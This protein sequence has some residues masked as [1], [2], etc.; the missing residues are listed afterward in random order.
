M[1]ATDLAELLQKREHVWDAYNHLKGEEET[2]LVGLAPSLRGGTGRRRGTL[3][4][5]PHSASVAKALLP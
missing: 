5:L 4:D 1:A 3:I 2:H